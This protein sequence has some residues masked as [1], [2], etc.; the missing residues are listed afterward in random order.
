[1]SHYRLILCLIFFLQK[2]DRTCLDGKVNKAVF[3]TT[4]DDLNKLI[5]DILGKLSGHVSNTINHCFTR[6][7]DYEGFFVFFYIVLFVYRF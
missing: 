5:S 6:C 1:M 7:Y 4:L 3:D 2:A